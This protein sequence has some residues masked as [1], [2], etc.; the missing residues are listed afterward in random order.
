MLTTP[1]R[2]LLDASR[3]SPQQPAAVSASLPLPQWEHAAMSHVFAVALVAHAPRLVFLPGVAE[4]C[5]A[6]IDKR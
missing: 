2:A 4:E 1:P 3:P 5:A 6:R